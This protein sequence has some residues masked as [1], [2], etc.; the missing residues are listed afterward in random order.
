MEEKNNELEREKDNFLQLKSEYGT[1]L[2]GIFQLEIE[3]KK[4]KESNDKES[5]KI[6]DEID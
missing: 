2:T 1:V 5:S 4:L 6:K 3:T